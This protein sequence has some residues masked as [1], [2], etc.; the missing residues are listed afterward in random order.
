MTGGRGG[1]IRAVEAAALTPGVQEVDPR[2]RGFASWE[3]AG[4]SIVE[5]VGTSFLRG[6]RAALAA[7]GPHTVL[8]PLADSVERTHFGF[9]V[10]GAAMGAGV[11]SMIHPWERGF[12]DRFMTHAGERHCYMIYVGLGWA[13]ARVPRAMWPRLHRFDR[14]RSPLILDGYGFHETF[15][16]TREILA[17]GRVE[18]PARRWWAGRAQVDQY[19]W[20][21]VGR[22]LWFVSGGSPSRADRMLTQSFPTEAH[23]SLWAGLGLAMTYAGGL[24]EAGAAEALSRSGAARGYLRQGSAFAL[25]ARHRAG[26]TTSATIEAA[27]LLCGRTSAEVTALV[28]ASGPPP[29]EIDVCADAAYAQ[30]RAATAGRLSGER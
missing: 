11:R 24:D 23:S 16:R 13:L 4:A 8:A 14:S 12:F 6:Y 9:A 19:L 5:P 28:A 22:A 10:E 27:E 17:T 2:V 21:G 15:F 1:R 25:E 30:W 7:R 18:F 3:G 29:H 20:Q 26:T